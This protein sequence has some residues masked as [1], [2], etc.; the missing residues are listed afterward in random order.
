M[1][2]EVAAR[3]GYGLYQ[4]AKEEDTV[5]E[6]CSQCE[7]LLTA[8]EESDDLLI[9]LRAVKI[10]AEEKKEYLESTFKDVF[11]KDMINFLKLLVDKDRTYYLKEILRMYIELADDELGI[12]KAIVQSA[13]PLSEADMQEIK[14]AL[15]KNTGKTIVLQNTVKPELI[16]GIKVIVGNTVTDNTFKNKMETLKQVLLKGG[17]A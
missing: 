8:L 5:A 13:K 17:R 11:D 2:S 1:I 15:E 6:K 14:T 9:F 10:T 4:L 16:A 7:C 3:Y 12:Q